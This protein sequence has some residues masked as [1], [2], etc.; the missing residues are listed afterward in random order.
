MSSTVRLKLLENA[1]N[2]IDDLR[3]VKVTAELDQAKNGTP[4]TYQSYCDLLLA[5][6]S[7]YDASKGSNKPKNIRK[8]SYHD[9]SPDDD[10]LPEDNFD[11]DLSPDE[12]LE[13]NMAQRPPPK[14][15]KANPLRTLQSQAG[16]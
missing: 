3:Q 7:M 15:P 8:I 5:A 11:I 13:I 16:S 10:S 6:A 12:F 4:L 14:P 9:F 1:V 2:G